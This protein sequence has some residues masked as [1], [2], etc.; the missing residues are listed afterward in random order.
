MSTPPLDRRRFLTRSAAGLGALSTVLA[1]G[2]DP[3]QQAAKEPVQAIPAEDV[4]LVGPRP[5][6]KGPNVVL[7]RFGGG[8]RRRETVAFPDQ[9]WCPFVVHELAQQGVLFTNVEIANKPGVSTSHGQGTLFILTGQYAHYEDFEKRPL[10]E[11]FVSP[12]PTIF[13]YLRR[14]Y[15]IPEYQ[16]LIVNGEDRVNEDFYTFSNHHQYGIHYKSTVL[17]LY[18]FKTY[19]LREEVKHGNFSEPVR[20]Q[21]EKQLRE[22]EAKDYR[23]V[24]HTVQSP[25]LDRF[26]EGWKQYYGTTGLVNPRGDRVLTALALRAI[27]EL[28]PRLMMVNYQD[29]DYVHWGNP[30]FY[31]RA[32]AIMDDGIRQIYDAVQASESYRNNTVF[33]VVP[34]CGRDDNRTMSVPFQHHFNTK[35]AHE[36]FALIAWPRGQGPAKKTVVNRSLQQQI[37]VTRTVGEIM[38]FATPHAAADSLLKVV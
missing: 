30:H 29:A 25:E 26:W 35:S 12:I 24:D 33:V 27:K 36:I 3:Q 19:L 11:R 15:D 31:T 34:D 2:C 13:E 32:L 22:M 38:N 9:T 10:A 21:K 23:T 28:Q 8:V 16:T 37:S 7:I 20:A 17:S 1:T 4:D 6:Y 18:R 5:P 14:T